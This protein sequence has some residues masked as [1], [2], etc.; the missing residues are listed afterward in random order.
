MFWSA[1]KRWRFILTCAGINQKG[2]LLNFNVKEL[3][4]T[5]DEVSIEEKIEGNWVDIVQNKFKKINVCGSN[6]VTGLLSFIR[7]FYQKETE[8]EILGDELSDCVLTYFPTFPLTLYR[9]LEVSNWLEEPTFLPF[10]KVVFI[11]P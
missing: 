1:K 10:T 8:L 7:N 5:I 4:K 2:I 6:T 9:I 3:H 11:D